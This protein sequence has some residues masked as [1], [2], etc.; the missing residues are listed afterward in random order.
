MKKS[1]NPIIHALFLLSMLIG[2][3]PQQTFSLSNR[4]LTLLEAGD[5]H[6]LTEPDLTSGNFSFAGTLIVDGIINAD[7][8]SITAENIVIL[9][10]GRIDSA[11]N[12]TLIANDLY[13]QE[14]DLN[15]SESISVTGF[16]AIEMD[17]GVEAEKLNFTTG[18]LSAKGNWNLFPVNPF[19]PSVTIIKSTFTQDF[20]VDLETREN[21]E[22][23]FSGPTNVSGTIATDRSI[24]F[25]GG[26]PRI[27]LSPLLSLVGIDNNLPLSVSTRA[28]GEFFI[29]TPLNIEGIFLDTTVGST[30]LKDLTVSNF[31]AGGEGDITI[32]NGVNIFID[33]SLGIRNRGAFTLLGNMDVIHPNPAQAT[34]VPFEIWPGD[35]II[36]QGSASI[37]GNV[38]LSFVAG[39]IDFEPGDDFINFGNIDIDLEVTDS[40]PFQS[41]QFVNFGSIDLSTTPGN[42]GSLIIQSQIPVSISGQLSADEILFFVLGNP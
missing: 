29:N 38:R 19:L 5:I 40:I 14:G 39:F 36:I 2:L 26:S 27:E 33:G 34:N 28:I 25:T 12:I 41:Y 15:A 9:D 31:G 6:V 21:T 17:G 4:A 10:S 37:T 20:L 1:I 11:S 32:Q 18:Q 35:E 42:T 23:I 16:H 30:I 3:M 7:N 13:A 8:V 22:F 24:L